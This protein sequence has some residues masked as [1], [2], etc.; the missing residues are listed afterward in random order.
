MIHAAQKRTKS[1]SKNDSEHKSSQ[2]PLKQEAETQSALQLQLQ[3]KSLSF[4]AVIL[5]LNSIYKKK[6][7]SRLSDS[8]EQCDVHLISPNCLQHNQNS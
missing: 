1:V 4:R 8:L 2:T 3:T 7:Q 5:V 6:R